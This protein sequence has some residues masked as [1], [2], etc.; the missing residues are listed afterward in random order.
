MASELGEHVF[1]CA[2]QNAMAS[3][4]ATHGIR[5]DGT[6]V[7]CIEDTARVYEAALKLP[8]EHQPW[9][10]HVDDMSAQVKNTKLNKERTHTGWKLWG[11]IANEVARLLELRR[12]SNIALIAGSWVS[13]PEGADK[14]GGPRV[15]TREL[16]VDL[17]ALFDVL[18]HGQRGFYGILDRAVDNRDPLYLCKDRWNVV[19]ADMPV[20]MNLMAILEMQE[21]RGAEGGS[22]WP[23]PVPWPAL[24]APH[25]QEAFDLTQMLVSQDLGSP[26]IFDPSEAPLLLS[27]RQHFAATRGCHRLHA[28]WLTRYILAKTW[29]LRLAE[30]RWHTSL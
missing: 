3:G 16:Q 14:K 23:R 30:R 15:P 8:P 29:H 25:R 2:D 12:Q 9:A 1:H 13:P 18:L 6:Q 24:V 4:A 22:P 28:S 11:A 19:L 26:L 17:P 27:I 5:A 7:T 10:I 20:P 21:M